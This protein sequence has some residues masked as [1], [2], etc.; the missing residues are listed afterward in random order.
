MRI[1]FRIIGGFII[2]PVFALGF[3]AYYTYTFETNITLDGLGRQ[4]YNSPWF[5]K[6]IM[7]ED[8]LWAGW[9]WFICDVIIFWGGIISGF[10]LIM[11]GFNNEKPSES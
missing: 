6:L 4:L 9:I 1:L 3:L 11:V 5:I 7:G 2:L 8:R 10:A